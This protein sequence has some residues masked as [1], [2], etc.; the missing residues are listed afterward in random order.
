MTKE[1]RNKLL[2]Y[3]DVM[4]QYLTTINLFDHPLMEKMFTRKV[5]AVIRQDEDNPRE[6][7]HSLVE[8]MIKKADHC[9]SQ[10]IVALRETDHNHVANELDPA[11][12]YFI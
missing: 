4:T 6:T 3:E 5:W 10:F 8:F 9:F 7:V 1:H 2:E 12:T 11:G